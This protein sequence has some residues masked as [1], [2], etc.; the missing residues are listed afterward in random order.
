MSRASNLACLAIAAAR[1]GAPDEARRLLRK[2]R[3]LDARCE[4][5]ARA[6]GAREAAGSD[7]DSNS[8]SDS[9]S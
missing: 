8:D 9:D 2:A 5:L 6:E 7:A 4:V 1:R 3:K